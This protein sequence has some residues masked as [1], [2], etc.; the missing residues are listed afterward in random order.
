LEEVEEEVMDGL[1]EEE[2][3]EEELPQTPEMVLEVEVGELLV[4]PQR[5]VLVLLEMDMTEDRSNLEV[6]KR[7]EVPVFYSRSNRRKR[8]FNS[9]RITSPFR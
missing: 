6:L 8:R 3:K 7:F 9:I 1:T 2:L 5:L 4:L